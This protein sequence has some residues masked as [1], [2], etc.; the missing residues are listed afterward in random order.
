MPDKKDIPNHHFMSL[1]FSL[2]QSIMALLGKIQNPATGKM[3]Q[4]LDQAKLTI[5]MLEMLKEK[6]KGNLVPTEEKMLLATLQ[7]IYL[8][9]ADEIKKV[10]GEKSK[11]EE[12]KKEEKKK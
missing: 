4:N 6:T 5:D 2:S 11:P 3:E 1:V 10:S 9:Y 12:P 7:N 8:N